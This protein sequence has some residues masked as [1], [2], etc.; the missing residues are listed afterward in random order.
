MLIEACLVTVIAVTCLNE[1]KDT[2]S[3]AVD[4]TKATVIVEEF[5]KRTELIL[6]AAEAVDK[7]GLTLYRAVWE[8]KRGEWRITQYTP[9][10]NSCTVS[11]PEEYKEQHRKEQRSNR[12]L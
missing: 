9:E 1:A 6:K 5:Q 4:S 2:K 12:W 11:T 3:C 8:N 7:A 10:K